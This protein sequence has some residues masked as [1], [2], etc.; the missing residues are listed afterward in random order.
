MPAHDRDS[1]WMVSDRTSVAAPYCVGLTGGIASGK[2]AVA[3][4]FASL[5]VAIADADIAAREAVAIDSEGLADVVAAFGPGILDTQGALDRAKMR[6]IVFADTDARARL[7]AI[8]HPR[9]RAVLR[10]QCEAATS[11]YAIAAIPLLAEVGGREAYPWLRRIL[12]VDVP[13]ETQHARLIQRDGIDAAL[14]DRMIA[15]QADKAKRLAIADDVLVNDRDL[16]SLRR[17][18]EALDRQYRRIAL[19]A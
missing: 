13:V 10:R 15:A 11:P 12:V 19:T 1:T 18:I 3:D 6:A 17:Q 14:A 2:S 16:A 7:E 9:V 4:A 8:V 5:G